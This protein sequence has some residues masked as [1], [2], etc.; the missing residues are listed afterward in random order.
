MDFVVGLPVSRGYDAIWVV[1]DHLTNLRYIVPCKST[2]SSEDLA[3]H[4][5]HNV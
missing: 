1:V 2:C 5:L 3:N 4:F